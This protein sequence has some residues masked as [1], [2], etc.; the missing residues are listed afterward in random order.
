MTESAGAGAGAG[1]LAPSSRLHIQ[2]VLFLSVGVK[3]QADGQPPH[4]VLPDVGATNC[5]P[6]GEYKCDVRA[7]ARGG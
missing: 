3:K 5:E 6:P 7:R 4:Q 2:S 1:G